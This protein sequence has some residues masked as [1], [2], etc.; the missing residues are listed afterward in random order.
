MNKETLIQNMGFPSRT[1]ELEGNP[2]LVYSGLKT[3]GIGAFARQYYQHKL[4]FFRAGR[5]NSWLIQNNELPV[6]QLNIRII[7]PP[8]VY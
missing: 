4:F 2:V 3:S 8:R 6:E 5:V 1:E 7:Q